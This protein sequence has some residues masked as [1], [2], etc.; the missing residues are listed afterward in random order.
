MAVGV[1]QGVE[2]GHRLEYHE[3]GTIYAEPFVEGVLH[4]LAKQY[5]PDGTLLIVSP[6]RNGTGTDCWCDLNGT[7]AEERPMKAGKPSGI[8]RWW[9]ED[10]RTVYSEMHWQDG[11]WHGIRRQWANG[12]LLPGFPEFFLLGKK[13]SKRAYLRKGMLEPDV[14]RYRSED[15]APEREFPEAFLR[16]QQR[17][18]RL[19]SRRGPSR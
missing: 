3:D 6:F 8:E 7:L 12:R 13:V 16:L 17:A 4:G 19:N 18:R 2:V 14:P 9:D 5:H 10:Q 1:R 11:K 15:D